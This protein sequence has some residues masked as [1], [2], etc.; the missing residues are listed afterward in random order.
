MRHNRNQKNAV[1]ASGRVGRIDGPGGV[2]LT[3]SRAQSPPSK[4]FNEDWF[5]IVVQ[6]YVRSCKYISGAQFGA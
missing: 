2:L 1:S 6:G 3:T 4:D 5:K